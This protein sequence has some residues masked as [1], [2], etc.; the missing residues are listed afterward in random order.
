MTNTKPLKLATNLSLPL[1]AATQTFA[2]LG[3]RG[4]GKTNTAVDMLEELLKAGQQCVWIDPVDVAWGI[5]SS[6]DGQAAGFPVTILGGEH[7]DVPLEGDAGKVVAD[8]VVDQGASVILSLRH[9]S[10]SEQ[11]RFA[12]DFAERLYDRKGKAEHRDPLH[13]FVDECDE[14]VPQKIPSGY[15]RM[16]GAFDRIVRRGRSSGIGVTLI[17][18]RPQVVNKDVLSQ[19]ET[20]ICHRLLHKLDRKA[21]EDWI[22]AHDTEGRS[23]VFMQSLASLARGEAWV[24]SP[25]WLNIFQ[26]VQ[27]RQRETFDSSATPAAGARLVAPKRVAEVDLNA[28]REKLKAT[29]D[30]AKADDPKELKRQIAELTKQ[31]AAKPATGKVERI[32]QAKLMEAQHAEIYQI[33]RNIVRP[34]IVKAFGHFLDRIKEHAEKALVMERTLREELEREDQWKVKFITK[35]FEKAIRSAIVDMPVPLKLRPQKEW[36]KPFVKS[37]ANSDETLPIGELTVL[38]VLAQ[39]PNGLQRQQISVFSGYSKRRTRDTYIQRL[40]QRGYAGVLSDGRVAITAEGKTNVGG[41]DE[42]PTGAALQEWWL[43][44]LPKGEAEVLRTLCQEGALSR[45]QI[46]QL[47]GYHARRTRDTYIQRLQQK[48][49]VVSQNG[50]IAPSDDLF[51]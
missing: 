30:K 16:F 4:S 44:K 29:I 51:D 13:L 9:L 17:S 10:M 1:N 48:M 37:P 8:F 41:F 35:N 27:M 40:Q 49:L 19:C 36:P 33:M 39:Y 18:Q 3:L 47:T 23:E 32:D 15:E 21:V 31:L 45:D 20:L 14:F 11:R 2:I 50:E 6:R 7:G 22:Q 12:M 24:W 28:L 43:A 26:R 5:K 46:S 42:L 34:T 38:R 25:S